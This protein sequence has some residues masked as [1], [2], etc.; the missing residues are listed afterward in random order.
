MIV[1]VECIVLGLIFTL[2]VYFMSKNPI[3]T[4]YNYPYKIQERVKTLNQY[5]NQIPTQNN[6]I[7]TKLS[8]S[9]F[10][11]IFVSLILRYINGYTTFQESFINSF[12]IWTIINIYDVIV[13]DIC[14]FCQDKRFIFNGTEDLINEYKNYWFHIKE[15]I[16]G[17]LIGTIICILIGLIIHFVL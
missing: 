15:G 14:W 5:K 13:L 16:I 4:L 11:I 8:V 6:K 17:E 7:V 2:M 3:K 12:I 9:I 1:I 10:I